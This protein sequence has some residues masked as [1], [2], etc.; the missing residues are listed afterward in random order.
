M[1][2]TE[3]MTSSTSSTTGTEI[4]QARATVRFAGRRPRRK[5]PGLA[6]WE[7]DTP[8]FH[9]V[10]KAAFIVGVCLLV[11]VPLWM[12]VITSLSSERAISESGGMVL[13]PRGLSL[14]AYRM[15]FAGESVPRALTVSIGVT[16]AGTFLSTAVTA[17]AAYGL[18][19][20]GSLLHRPL[21]M[22]ILFTYLFGP[23][24]IPVYLTVQ[25]LGLIDTYAALI[26]PSLVAAFNLIILR[27]FFMGIPRELVDSARIDGASEFTIL[28]RIILPLSKAPIAVVALFYGVGYW[29]NFFSALLYL[30]D[31]QKWPLQLL[32]RQLVLQGRSLEGDTGAQQYMQAQ[33]P[34]VAVQMA[35]VVVAMVPV[36]IAYPFVQRH[37]VKGVVIGAVKG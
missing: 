5:R 31:A 16:A 20:P 10:V 12:V 14:D 24:M 19:R 34:D 1:T 33:A 26:L 35:V 3:N 23:S 13:I 29:N 21:L 11:A 27:T 4:A 18:S 17:L 30:N 28:R 9:H 2:T 36:L 15:I 8:W 7:D 25:N 32:L 37:F 22:I 6:P